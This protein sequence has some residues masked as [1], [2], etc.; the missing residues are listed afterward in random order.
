MFLIV[1][2]AESL[3][4]VS[5]PSFSFPLFAHDDSFWTRFK[6]ISSSQFLFS[7][8]NFF[9][10]PVIFLQFTGSRHCYWYS[11]WGCRTGNLCSHIRTEKS[12]CYGFHWKIIVK[13]YFLTKA[14]YDV[15]P[16]RWSH[17]AHSSGWQWYPPKGKVLRKKRRKKLTNVSFA[18]SPTYVQ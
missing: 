16:A 15:I 10:F 2:P 18:L 13:K 11:T 3:P 6:F 1:V 5:S 8:F 9:S 17:L 14:W 12:N 4:F 7:F